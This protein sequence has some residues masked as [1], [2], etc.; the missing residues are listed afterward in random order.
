ML[1]NNMLLSK[2]IAYFEKTVEKWK[3]DLGAVYDVI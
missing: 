1:I 2:Y 3:S